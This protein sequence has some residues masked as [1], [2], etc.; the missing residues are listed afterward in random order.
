M[1]GYENFELNI[2]LI[3]KAKRYKNLDDY[4]LKK[5]SWVKKYKASDKTYIHSWCVR[6]KDIKG[7]F[8]LF[9]HGLIP[10][11][12]ECGGYFCVLDCAV[13]N[14][15][16]N[17]AFYL[18][19]MGYTSNNCYNILERFR[20]HNHKN[21]DIVLNIYP[22]SSLKEAIQFY[23]VDDS[24]FH[25]DS[26]M[27]L[28]LMKEIDLPMNNIFLT[29]KNKTFVKKLISIGFID[30]NEFWNYSI[31]TYLKPER[32]ITR[33]PKD[34]ISETVALCTRAGINLNYVYDDTLYDMGKNLPQTKYERREYR[35][36]YSMKIREIIELY[37]RYK[38]IMDITKVP[39]RL[40]YISKRIRG[41]S[42]DND[43]EKKFI[44][45]PIVLFA[46]VMKFLV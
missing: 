34:E 3:L 25:E 46:K 38:K 26:D 42:S 39:R 1:M 15:D 35:Q 11:N 7:L 32:P 30:M 23:I 10:V 33:R 24:F 9:S 16:F 43:F 20:T 45:L 19:S 2:I 17:T 21:M 36:R 6:A 4:L 8:I 44:D 40:P 37:C 29:P 27:L 5:S 13:E 22:S 12:I 41:I 18:Q 14:N 31:Y 28:D